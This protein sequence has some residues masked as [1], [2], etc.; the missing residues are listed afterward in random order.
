MIVGDQ[1]SLPQVH[2]W[3]VYLAKEPNFFGVEK[4]DQINLDD[5]E[6]V[7]KIDGEYAPF[8]VA[9]NIDDAW[10]NNDTTLE[11]YGNN[12]GGCRSLSV[13][14]VICNTITGQCYIVNNIGYHLLDSDSKS[15]EGDPE[16]MTNKD[17]RRRLFLK[18]Q[19]QGGVPKICEVCQDSESNL[20]YYQEDGEQFVVCRDCL[21]QSMDDWKTIF[22]RR[23]NWN[24]ESKSKNVK[25]MKEF[26]AILK[27]Y[28]LK[29]LQKLK[30]QYNS[31]DED[32]DYFQEQIDGIKSGKYSKN[33]YYDTYI[34]EQL[35]DSYYN[36]VINIAEAD[37]KNPPQNISDYNW[38]YLVNPDD[39]SFWDSCKYDKIPT[40]K[41]KSLASIIVGTKNFE[42]QVDNNDRFLV[43]ITC[44][45]CGKPYDGTEVLDEYEGQIVHYRCAASD[46]YK[47]E[48][49]AQY[50]GNNCDDCGGFLR[51][52][53]GHTDGEP[54][55]QAGIENRLCSKCGDG[56]RCDSCRKI[57]DYYGGNNPY[58]N[59]CHQ[60]VPYNLIS[61]VGESHERWCKW[62]AGAGQTAGTCE[63]CWS[64]PWMWSNDLGYVFF[65]EDSPYY[66]S[67]YERMCLH[68][69][70]EDFPEIYE[71]L[72]NQPAKVSP[73]PKKN[74]QFWKSETF[75]APSYG[76]YYGACL[77]PDGSCTE[78][79]L[80][81][82]QHLG[83]RFQG[84]GTSC[85]PDY[86]WARPRIMTA[87]GQSKGLGKGLTIGI[88]AGIIS[89]LVTTV[90]GTVI[91]EI[92]LDR[93]REDPELE[94]TDEELDSNNTP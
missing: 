23:P 26:I 35:P 25:A 11:V 13:S 94:I 52:C 16:W 73:T 4:G 20:H 15:A 86:R 31:W 81:M 33:I 50:S 92:L 61:N 43:D 6:L 87:E 72:V 28:W 9:Q 78:T 22:G 65:D 63:T 21:E 49:E 68:C 27:P 37:S 59:V 10:V 53:I 70:E 90:F 51:D 44:S 42:A 79:T 8:Q 5:Y 45:W 36:F 71:H 38:D 88:V 85:D 14:D 48:F 39:V 83:G 84:P 17:L 75:E 7:A 12:Q 57:Y 55:N 91:S 77:L 47:A 18:S 2:S 82:C 40:R 80:D 60:M 46:N 64:E 24:A 41:L 62:D 1:V 58:C 93:L 69:M 3:Q 66:N 56:P 74:W 32:R 19:K 67:D 89:G 30:S 76:N 29:E 54:C 34:R